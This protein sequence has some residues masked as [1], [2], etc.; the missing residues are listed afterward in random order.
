MNSPIQ[1]RQLEKTDVRDSKSIISSHRDYG[2]QQQQI[3]KIGGVNLA[4]QRYHELNQVR[5]YHASRHS[6][7]FPFIH[8]PLMQSSTRFQKFAT[9][10]L[11][12]NQC[13]TL[14]QYESNSINNGNKSHT[15]TTNVDLINRFHEFKKAATFSCG[16]SLESISS[17]KMNLK[18]LREKHYGNTN[19]FLPDQ[20]STQ[21]WSQNHELGHNWSRDHQKDEFEFEPTLAKSHECAEITCAQSNHEDG[22][23][24]ADSFERMTIDNEPIT[25][26]MKDYIA[27][28]REYK[29]MEGYRNS[30][31]KLK[32]RCL[33]CNKSVNLSKVFF[34]C[35]HRCVCDGC[36]PS[37]VK[38]YSKQSFPCPLCKQDVRFV[39]NHDNGNEVELY[40]KWVD[41]VKPPI[42]QDFLNGFRR[43]SQKN[44]SRALSR[45]IEHS[46]AMS[47][48]RGSRACIIS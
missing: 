42:S 12:Q 43:N 25:E 17:M 28:A 1:R 32:S 26:Q 10:L 6:A 14:Q 40:W 46:D 29:R 33:L 4:K 8:R 3:C 7:T 38:N 37:K 21:F 5:S 19:T 45:G 9:P 41:E 24:Y 18:Q 31:P 11:T 35:E 39:A 16:S 47:N 27:A 34:P 2:S 30:N 13:S 23:K 20:S 15:N 44:I 22:M 36:F 48:E